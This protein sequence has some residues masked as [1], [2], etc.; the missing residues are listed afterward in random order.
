[1]VSV[2]QD[3]HVSLVAQWCPILLLS[4]PVTDSL[5]MEV[6]YDRCAGGCPFLLQGSHH[7]PGVKPGLHLADAGYQMSFQAAFEHKPSEMTQ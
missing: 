1:M 2:R 5:S 6:L 4:R 3:F 7:D